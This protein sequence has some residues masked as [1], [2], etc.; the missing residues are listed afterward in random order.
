MGVAG[1]RSTGRGESVC[2]GRGPRA[3]GTGFV[4]G[5]WY[6]GLG[7]VYFGR[8]CAAPKV[9]KDNIEIATSNA[10]RLI[11]LLFSLAKDLSRETLPRLP[12]PFGT[13]ELAPWYQGLNLYLFVLL[14]N[15]RC[16]TGCARCFRYHRCFGFCFAGLL[17]LHLACLAS[18]KEVLVDCS[19]LSSILLV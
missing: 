11:I 14:C 15:C 5:A 12:T 13:P 6:T 17:G 10:K 19:E 3:G 2:V 9:T 18:A 1:R 8:N 16:R 7:G 4:V